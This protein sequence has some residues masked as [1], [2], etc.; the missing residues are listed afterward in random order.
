MTREER[1]GGGRGKGGGNLLPTGQQ[2]VQHAGIFL[3]Q[4]FLLKLLVLH[5]Y[6]HINACLRKHRPRTW[7]QNFAPRWTKGKG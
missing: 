7:L 6:L 5:I 3:T 2:E 4:E 1:K